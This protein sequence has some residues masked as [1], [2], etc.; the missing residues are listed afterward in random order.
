MHHGIKRKRPRHG[1]NQAWRTATSAMVL[2]CLIGF[3]LVALRCTWMMEEWPGVGLAVSTGGELLGEQSPI[4]HEWTQFV[5]Y[6]AR[7]LMRMVRDTEGVRGRFIYNLY[8]SGTFKKSSYNVLRHAG[9]VFAM[10]SYI[11]WFPRHHS[12]GMVVQLDEFTEKT[13]QAVD[14]LKTAFLKPLTNSNTTGVKAL[15]MWDE[16]SLITKKTNARRRCAKLGGA[17]LGLVAL[18][19]FEAIRP[20]MTRLN[21]LALLAEF[22]KFMQ[23]DDGSFD[24]K[25]CDTFGMDDSVLS[26]YYPG[27]ASLGMVQLYELTKRREYLRVA[28]RG[29]LYLASTRAESTSVERDHWALLATEKLLKHLHVLRV[30]DEGEVRQR[31]LYHGDQIVQSLI[32]KTEDML[33]KTRRMNA[34]GNPPMPSDGRTTPT[35]THLEGLMAAMSF[36]QKISEL[37]MRENAYVSARF[38]VASQ[39][40]HV[41]ESNMRH[42]GI[43]AAVGHQDTKSKAIRID[44]VQHAICGVMRAIDA[45]IPLLETI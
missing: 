9:A 40:R 10:A 34:T 12:T 36:S 39:I 32:Q 20:G 21:D 15:A 16:P 42:G 3:A 11:Q 38:L 27:E 13:A 26:L 37:E 23:R 31:L 1:I 43:P 8:E 18:T 28:L 5:H 22:I 29:I 44:Y 4:E 2:V 41:D 17:G 25:Y 24:S 35:A 30:E 33:R 45:G 7:Y 19:S 14:Y 6:G